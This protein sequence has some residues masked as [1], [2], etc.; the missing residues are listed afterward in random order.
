MMA[1]GFRSAATGFPAP[2]AGDK[3]LNSRL[4]APTWFMRVGHIDQRIETYCGDTDQRAP[5]PR[6]F[7]RQSPASLATSRD[8]TLTG[9]RRAAKELTEE[10]QGRTPLLPAGLIA[11]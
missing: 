3:K 5:L 10:V 4:A 6:S 1:G 8:R 11:L 9:Y 7:L 2:D